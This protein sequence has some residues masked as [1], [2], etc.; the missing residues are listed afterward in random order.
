M[1]E[2]LKTDEWRYDTT[3]GQP[4]S[5]DGCGVFG[6]LRKS[7]AKPISNTEAVEGISCISYRGSN[8]GAG[9]AC[10]DSLNDRTLKV[11]AFVSNEAVAR[12]VLTKLS[13]TLG[14]PLTSRIVGFEDSPNGTDVLNLEFEYSAKVLSSIDR[15]VDDINASLLSNKRIDGR[16]FSYGKYLSVFKGVGYPLDIARMYGID[17]KDAQFG[18]MWIAHTRQPTNSPGSSPIWSHPFAALDC[19]IVHN[20]DI[21]SFGANMELLNSLGYKS[22]VGTDSEVVA[23][24]LNHLIRVEGLSVVDAATVL[25]NPFEDR[26]RGNVLLETL[27]RL[28][29]ARLDGPFA[30]LAGY[31]D[32]NDTYLIALTDRSKFRPLLFGEDDN[33]YFVASEENQIRRISPKARVWTPEPGSVFIASLKQGLIASGNSR[34]T[35]SSFSQKITIPP[36]EKGLPNELSKS[37]DALDLGFQEING[38]IADA[39]EAGE[40]KIGFSNLNGQ[41]YIA[42]GFSP[43][44]TSREFQIELSGYPGNCLA[45]LNDGGNFEIFGNVAD[46]LGDTMH[47]GKIIVHGSARDVVGQALQGGEIFIQGS[48]GNRAAIQM[49]EY[50]DHRPFLVVGETADDYLGEYMAGGVVV[51]LNMSDQPKSVGGYVGTGMVGGRIYIRGKVREEQLGLP[52][53][54]ADILNYLRGYVLDQS[55]S[56]KDFETIAA[57]DFPGEKALQALLAPDIFK[58][59]RTVFF[60]GKYTKPISTE[61]RKLDPRRDDLALLEQKIRSFFHHFGV[62]LVVQES[63]MNSEFTVIQTIEDEERETPIPPQEV[64]V[65]E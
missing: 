64:P 31:E 33:C 38:K 34:E 28:K 53:K 4:I 24:L 27:S 22:H 8:L 48:V 19:A 16:I 2:V 51:V 5:K 44:K 36:S 61:Y 7:G 12:S 55:I 40:E 45:N 32:D 18:D 20:G 29:G 62:P 9:Y 10:F 15:L 26:I 54:K 46:D 57:L 41:R 17:R 56:Q 63:I 47:A 25:T 52:P 3:F 43:R 11:G 59:V 6:V 30:I 49:R 65:E 42:I 13:D 60:K 50:K 21:S 37:I 39:Y 58:R 23:R 1:L 14:E 35:G